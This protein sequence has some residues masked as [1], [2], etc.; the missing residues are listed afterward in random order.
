MAKFVK[1]DVVVVPFPFS[2]LTQSKRRPAL[3]ITALDGDDLILCQVTS[4]TIKDKYAIAVSDND[5]ETGELKQPSNIR[6][7]RIFTADTHII[8]YRVG[9]L[10]NTKVSEVIESIVEIIR[11]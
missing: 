5:F 11:K 7:N 6:P 4:K 1:G 3:V 2:D 9:N 8:L 10:K